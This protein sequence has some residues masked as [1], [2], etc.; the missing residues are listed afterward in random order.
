MA[1]DQP[2]MYGS[3]MDISTSWKDLEIFKIHVCV[4]YEILKFVQILVS[5]I[6]FHLY[7]YNICLYRLLSSVVCTAETLSHLIPQ[8]NFC[9]SLLHTDIVHCAQDGATSCQEAESAKGGQSEEQ[10]A[11]GGANNS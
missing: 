2:E 7:L 10:D 8:S 11:C 4:S 6:G 5:P 3:F 9:V 1:D